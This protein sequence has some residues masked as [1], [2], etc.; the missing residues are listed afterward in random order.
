MTDTRYT[1]KNLEDVEDSAPGFGIGDMQEARFAYGA[2]DCDQVGFALERVKPGKRQAFAHKHEEAEEV[3]VVI[4][5]SGRVKLDDEVIE[6]ARLDA[7]RVA[8]Q[9]MRQFEAGPDGL[10]LIAFGQRHTGDGEV[11]PGWWSD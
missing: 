3:Y 6:L 10:E 7:L 9:V 8:P 4:S 11:A 1:H 2:L 5:G